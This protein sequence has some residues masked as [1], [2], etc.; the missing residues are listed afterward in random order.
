MRTENLVFANLQKFKNKKQNFGAIEDAID[1]E[2]SSFID[3]IM[4]L[5]RYLTDLDV[6]TQDLN[7]DL[8]YFKTK[9]ETYNNL[10]SEISDWKSK[11]DEFTSIA[12]ELSQ[13]AYNETKYAWVNQW[14]NV[15]SRFDETINFA[16]DINQQLK[17]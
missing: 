12:D 6:A 16:N 13:Y 3:K 14:D 15:T 11:Y 8:E 1:Q 9:L 10:Y 7:D 2:Q 4:P 17:F 5:S